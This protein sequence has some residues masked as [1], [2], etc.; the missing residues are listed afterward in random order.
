VQTLPSDAE[1]VSGPVAKVLNEYIRRP[2]Q[3]ID[4]ITGLR[5]LEINRET[6]LVSIHS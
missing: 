1:T 4:N 2:D 3:I 6:A 5:M